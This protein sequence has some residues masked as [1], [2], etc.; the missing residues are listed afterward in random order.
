M[1]SSC[2]N[3]ANMP[4]QLK[5]TR[6]RENQFRFFRGN[7]TCVSWLYNQKIVQLVKCC[8]VLVKSLRNKRHRIFLSTWLLLESSD[9]DVAILLAG[10]Y[11]K[12]HSHI[13][14]ESRRTRGKLW[15][16]RENKIM[17]RKTRH[18]NIQLCPHSIVIKTMGHSITIQVTLGN[19]STI[20]CSFN[21][22]EAYVV[23]S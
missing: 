19:I 12:K 20:N 13:F 4:H 15:K 6:S 5:P 18:N 17:S 23:K 21:L 9:Q 10:N 14:L 3:K 22:E 7:S 2:D 8:A 16:L 1:Y 11:A